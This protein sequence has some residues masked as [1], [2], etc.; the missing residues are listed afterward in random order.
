MANGD[1]GIEE[2]GV[3]VRGEPTIEIGVIGPLEMFSD[4]RDFPTLLA[5]LV[6]L[7]DALSEPRLC[8]VERE[9]V[10]R[11]REEMVR[12]RGPTLLVGLSAPGVS[13]VVGLGEVDVVRDAAVPGV[14]SSSVH[15]KC[16]MTDFVAHWSI[17]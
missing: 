7:L 14:S 9:D 5:R 16:R 17:H 1:W 4:N 12:R 8:G 10:E 3:A 2:T 13:G 6:G 15:C 11:E